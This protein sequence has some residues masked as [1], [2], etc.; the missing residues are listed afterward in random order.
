MIAG[1]ERR[2]IKRFTDERGTL[3]VL[4]QGD[5]VPFAIRRVFVISD[6]PSG[7]CR[8]GHR[9]SCDQLIAPLS[10]SCRLVVRA[11]G[12]EAIEWLEAG[13][14]AVLVPGGAWRLRDRFSPGAILLVCAPMLYSETHYEP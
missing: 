12:A 10:G 11:A 6:V 3:R 7:Q 1:L 4:E 14:D 9:V 8:A 5:H 2:M 13:D